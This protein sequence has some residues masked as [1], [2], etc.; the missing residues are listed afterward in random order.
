MRRLAVFL[1]ICFLVYSSCVPQIDSGLIAHYAFEGNAFDQSQFSHHGIIHGAYPTA[2][3]GGKQNSAYRFDGINDYILV[4]ASGFPPIESAM[5]LSWWFKID[6]LPRFDDVWGAGNIFALV[7]T[8][9]GIGVQ[10]GF[11]GPAYR[12][13]GLDTWNWGGG[14]LLE[15]EPPALNRWH[16]CVYVHDGETHR[17][18]LNGQ[19]SVNSDRATQTGQPTQLMF[20]NYP[21]GDQYFTGCLDEV[22]IYNRALELDEI[23]AL[24]MQP[25]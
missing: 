14:T 19:E 5:S 1:S 16:H 3:I 20:G 4:D 18:Y 11:R 2:G 21:T 8:A 10:V 25:E 17:F 13:L 6:S 23:N 15:V 22:R 12:S 7:D 9:S 24:F